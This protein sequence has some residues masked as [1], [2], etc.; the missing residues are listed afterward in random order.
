MD[1][2]TTL[3]K[4][5]LNILLIQEHQLSDLHIIK[6]TLLDICIWASGVDFS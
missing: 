5:K 6:G 2:H 1:T 4:I 3:I